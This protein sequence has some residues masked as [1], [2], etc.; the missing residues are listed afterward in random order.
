MPSMSIVNGWTRATKLQILNHDPAVAVVQKEWSAGKAIEMI[1][2]MMTMTT[3]QCKRE[4]DLHQ[5]TTMMMTM[6][7]DVRRCFLA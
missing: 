2:P 5:W 1:S 3:F 7:F 4:V 6:I